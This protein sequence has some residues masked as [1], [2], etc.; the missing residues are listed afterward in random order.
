MSRNRDLAERFGTP[1]YVY[2]LDRVAASLLDLR[3][4]V[5]AGTTIF[6][7]LK[8]NPH[9]EIARALREVPG[10]RCGAELSST[11]E[12]AA[13]L[14]AGF[15]AEECLY[16]GPG[17]TTG[18]IATAIAGGVRTFSI[19]SGSDLRRVGVV[20]TEAGVSVDCLLR[21]NSAASTAS[22]SIRMMGARSQFGIDSETLGRDLNEFRSVPGT[23]LVGGHFY[24][25]SN[26]KDEASLSAEL[27]H[28]IAEAAR[29]H[30][31]LDLPM[32]FLDIGGGFGAPY[33]VPGD[34]PRYDGLRAALEEAL[35]EHFPLWRSGLP[36]IACESGRYLAGDCGELMTSVMNVKE[37]RGQVFAIVDA[38][39]NTLGGMAGLGR[40]MPVGIKPD[41]TE[42]P[43]GTP[44]VTLAG[45]LCTPGDV[46]ARNV[47]LGW[48]APGDVLTVPNVGA[49]GLTASL[50]LFLSRP[51]A[52]EVVVRGEE[53]VAVSQLELRRTVSAL[54]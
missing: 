4:A 1:L 13:A 52:C 2:D 32:R 44:P 18:E 12:L 35:D 5:P 39:I 26:A 37:S 3:K 24:S 27:R 42:P 50:V 47:Q 29:L 51:A 9:P 31:E 45:P 53:V 40:L 33:A 30:A 43:E 28:S 19:E 6:Y 41:I 48:P 38:G 21:I 8:A 34:R 23:R 15:K 16:T 17:K 7:S 11:G 46:L 22:G 14:E 10:G 25:L 36:Q 20:A 49:Y 54:A